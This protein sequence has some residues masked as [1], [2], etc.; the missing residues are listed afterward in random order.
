MTPAQAKRLVLSLPRT[1]TPL[2]PLL[3]DQLRHTEPST[4]QVAQARK[5]VE[6]IGGI[7]CGPDGVG[8][9]HA[10]EIGSLAKR[11]ANRPLSDIDMMVTLDEDEWRSRRGLRDPAR[12]IAAFVE[13]LMQRY[14]A[15]EDAGTVEV[16]KQ[17]HSAGVRFLNDD[18]VNLDVVPA[19]RVRGEVYQIP[20][21]GSRRWVRTSPARQLETLNRMDTR[22]HAARRAIRLLKLWRDEAHIKLPSYAIEVLVL[23]NLRC[24]AARSEVGLVEATLR[25]MVETRLRVPV[26]LTPQRTPTRGVVIMGTGVQGNNITK[27]LDVANREKIEQ[28]AAQALARLERTCKLVE[29]G[30]DES[31]E[32]LLSQVFGD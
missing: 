8:G 3:Q 28:R 16:W 2:Q 15:Q 14:R 27:S 19:I 7:L 21:R 1:L 26:S 29:S 10:F 12:V 31:A 13:R 25:W 17:R 11:T 30:R 23:H 20:E 9:L 32:R 5:R 22:F 6:H 24:G 18:V 4:R